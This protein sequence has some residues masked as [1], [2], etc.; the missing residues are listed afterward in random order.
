MLFGLD[1]GS[2][3]LATYTLASTLDGGC[4]CSF[5]EMTKR[6]EKGVNENLAMF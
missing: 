1:I 6:N 4:A 5:L 2:F 3:F